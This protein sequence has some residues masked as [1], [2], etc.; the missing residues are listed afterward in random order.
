M[1]N[2]VVEGCGL[3]DLGLGFAAKDLIQ[4]MK[5][6][7]SI[8]SIKSSLETFMHIHCRTPHSQKQQFRPQIKSYHGWSGGFCTVRSRNIEVISS[9]SRNSVEKLVPKS[10]WINS[11]RFY[12]NNGPT[13]EQPW[14]NCNALNPLPPGGWCNLSGEATLICRIFNSYTIPDGCEI[15]EMGL[16]STEKPPNVLQIAP[17]LF[18]KPSPAH[19]CG[20]SISFILIYF[21]IFR[22]LTF[23]C[24]PLKPTRQLELTGVAI[25]SSSA[26]LLWSHPSWEP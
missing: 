25:N 20:A 15:W 11:C 19:I 2:S 13:L 23:W 3:L 1:I 22:F 24:D 16:T 14:S 5:A 26:W 18:T 10:V 17:S 12:L 8:L 21:D 9:R 6:V 7:V 4:P